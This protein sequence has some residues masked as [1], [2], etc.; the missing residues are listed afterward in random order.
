[1]RRNRCHLKEKFTPSDDSDDYYDD[2][3]GSC[4]A[5][6]AQGLDNTPASEEPLQLGERCS[7][8]TRALHTCNTL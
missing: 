1:M 6:H 3:F 7:I 8:W 2:D 5:S 4:T